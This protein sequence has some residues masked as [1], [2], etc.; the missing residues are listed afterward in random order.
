MVTQE[1]NHQSKIIELM[2][3]PDFYP[4]PVRTITLHETHISRVFLT[5]D[6]VYKIKKPVDL[7]FLDFTTLEK[8][9]HFCRREVELNQRLTHDIYHG[10]V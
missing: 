2:Q 9:R 3:T 1:N 8:R 6:F 7:D 5:G 4:H 10:V